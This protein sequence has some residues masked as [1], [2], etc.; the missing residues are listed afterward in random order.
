ME[1]VPELK[2]TYSKIFEGEFVNAYE[3]LKVNFTSA[4]KEMFN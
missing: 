1:K 3:C 2:G 4:T